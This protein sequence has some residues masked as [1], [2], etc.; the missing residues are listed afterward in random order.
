[1]YFEG[2]ATLD[3]DEAQ[4]IAYRIQEIGAANVPILFTVSPDQHYSWLN[5]VGGNYPVEMIDSIV[6]PRQRSLTFIR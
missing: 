4:Q 3:D 6:S 5:R 1:L 2:R